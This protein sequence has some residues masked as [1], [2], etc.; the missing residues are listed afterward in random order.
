MNCTSPQKHLPMYDL[1]LL[2]LHL[3]KLMTQPCLLL[4]ACYSVQLLPSPRWMLN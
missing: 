3:T 1:S 2:M 4:T